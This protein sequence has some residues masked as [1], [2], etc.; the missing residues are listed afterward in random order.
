MFHREILGSFPDSLRPLSRR[1]TSIKAGS[2]LSFLGSSKMER[3]AKIANCWKLLTFCR[4]LHLRYLTGFWIHLWGRP[5]PPS[6]LLLSE[7]IVR[8]CNPVIVVRNF[9]GVKYCILEIFHLTFHWVAN[10][11]FLSDSRAIFLSSLPGEPLLK[12]HVLKWMVTKFKCFSYSFS[13]V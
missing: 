6:I 5:K 9:K 1:K 4:T 7:S 13:N 8:K 11:P 10:E 12:F 3:F 2:I